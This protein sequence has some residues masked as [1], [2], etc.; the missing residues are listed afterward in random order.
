[1]LKEGI[2]EEV[3]NQH[4]KRELDKLGLDTYAVEKENLD[5]EEARKI[6]SSY[7][8][9]ITRKALKFV[10]DNESDDREAL[11]SQ[12]HTCNNVIS[13]LSEPLGDDELKLLEIDEEGEVLTSIYSKINNVRSLIMLA[14]LPKLAVYRI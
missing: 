10:G 5:V 8:S 11:L 9:T 3:I 2:Y 13:I 7:I 12:I 1:M 6:L 4:L 14:D